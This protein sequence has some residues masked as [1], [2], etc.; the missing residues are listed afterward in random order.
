MNEP[1][2][3]LQYPNG[4]VVATRKSMAE[5]IVKK[6]QAKYLKEALKETVHKETLAE[7]KSKAKLSDTK[8]AKE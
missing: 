2:V 8:K 4:A 1:M 5:R 6:K 7:A 3:S